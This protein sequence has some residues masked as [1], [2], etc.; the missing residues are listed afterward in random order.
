MRDSSHQAK[1]HNERTCLEVLVEIMYIVDTVDVAARDA[2][3][4]AQS[5]GHGH[6]NVGVALDHLNAVVGR[7]EGETSLKRALR[8]G[9]AL[10]SFALLSPQ[11]KPHRAVLVAQAPTRKPENRDA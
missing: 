7:D 9:F 8:L 1:A 5:I 10:A 6:D 4:K 2:L 11:L 3:K